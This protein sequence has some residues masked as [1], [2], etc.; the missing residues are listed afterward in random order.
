[1]RELEID[2]IAID[3]SGRLMI[4]PGNGRS[5]AMVYRAANGLRWNAEQSA[6]IAYEPDRWPHEELFAHIIATIEREC[7]ERFIVGKSTKWVSVS[8][9]LRNAM[10]SGLPASGVSGKS[11]T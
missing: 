1:M 3:S 4:R 6:I 11:D 8:N 9:E 10:L 5:Y 7:G 2:E